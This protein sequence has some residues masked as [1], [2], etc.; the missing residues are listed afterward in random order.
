MKI[1][2][3]TGCANED[4]TE[5]NVEVYDVFLTKD[6]WFRELEGLMEIFKSEYGPDV[7]YAS[8]DDKRVDVMYP[9]SFVVEIKQLEDDVLKVSIHDYD[10]NLLG[11]N[12]FSFP[13]D[14]FDED[15]DYLV[16][17]FGGIV[18]WVKNIIRKPLFKRR[19]EKLKQFEKVIGNDTIALY[20]LWE[21][22][23]DYIKRERSDN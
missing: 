21:P 22:D 3:E 8:I 18:T 9:E 20:K 2:H 17:F 12:N 10:H 6:N 15:P 19:Y 14:R 13:E 11:E 4:C 23:D 1:Y 5:I 16:P 7:I